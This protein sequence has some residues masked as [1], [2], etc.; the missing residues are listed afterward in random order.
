MYNYIAVD[1]IVHVPRLTA[2]NHLQ[3]PCNYIDIFVEYYQFYKLTVLPHR[4]ASYITKLLILSNVNEGEAISLHKMQV[5]ILLKFPYKLNI[6]VH[7]PML[8]VLYNIFFSLHFLSFQSLC[9]FYGVV[10]ISNSRAVLFH[11]VNFQK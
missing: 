11:N 8:K 1:K 6:P 9:R 5:T 4:Y 10:C 7:L 2:W 3:Y